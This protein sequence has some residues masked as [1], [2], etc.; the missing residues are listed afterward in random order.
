M[1][2]LHLLLFALLLPVA[3]GDPPTTLDECRTEVRDDYFSCFGWK[4]GC[5]RE[6]REDLDLCTELFPAATLRK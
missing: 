1:N 6:M 4:T 3:C 2:K 5:L